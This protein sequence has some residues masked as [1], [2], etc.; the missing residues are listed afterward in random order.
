ML[1]WILPRI[2]AD[3]NQ[4]R[5][6]LPCSKWLGLR[7]HMTNSRQKFP[8]GNNSGLYRLIADQRPANSLADEPTGRLDAATSEVV[9]DLFDR[10]SRNGMTLII[11][12]THDNTLEQRQRV[13]RLKDGDNNG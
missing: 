5:R 12:V 1:P 9:F 8:A 3:K 11:T 6:L 13:I 4:E 10:I 2:I 7:D